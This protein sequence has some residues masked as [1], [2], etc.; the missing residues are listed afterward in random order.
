[1]NILSYLYCKLLLG[2]LGTFVLCVI[3]FF[4]ILQFIFFGTLLGEGCHYCKT[5]GT[6]ANKLLYTFMPQQH[7]DVDV[8][9][10][11]V[12]SCHK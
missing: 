12:A 8:H 10:D 7:D 1:M 2:L 4:I 5:W 3:L 9:V 6:L 11:I